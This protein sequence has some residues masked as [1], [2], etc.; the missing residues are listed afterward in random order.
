[1]GKNLLGGVALLLVVS[2]IIMDADADAVLSSVVPL[3]LEYCTVAEEKLQQLMPLQKE[4]WLGS[5]VATSIVSINGSNGNG[6]AVWLFGDTLVGRLQ[7]GPNGELMRN[8]TSMPRNSIGW[9][10]KGSNRIVHYWRPEGANETG[11]FFNSKLEGRGNFL[12]PLVGSMGGDG[13]SMYV[14][15]SEV[16]NTNTGLHFE[17]VGTTLIVVDRALTTNPMEW[18]YRYVPL[19]WTNNNVS[20]TSSCTATA[21]GYLYV[22]GSVAGLA[23]PFPAGVMMRASLALLTKCPS[24]FEFWSTSSSWISSFS[25]TSQLQVVCDNVPTETTLTFLKSVG[26]FFLQIPYMDTRIYIRRAASIVGP[27][28]APEVI[29]D[30]PAPFNDTTKFYCYAP[31]VHVEFDS[32]PNSFV[33]TYICNSIKVDDLKTYTN[34]YVPTFLRTKINNVRE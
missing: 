13:S 2:G 8:W 24:C 33:F 1:M 9:L 29:Y 32:G 14:F 30:I 26:W 27:F 34:V 5:D 17:I 10:E 12:W 15:A 4:G 20:F 16:H 3:R 21:D 18:N 28:A 6:N 23:G 11:G 19:P 25:S 31:K 7:T 22:M